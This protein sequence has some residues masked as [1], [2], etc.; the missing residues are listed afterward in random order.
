M[1]NKVKH[2]ER[3]DALIYCRVSTNKQEEKDTIKSQVIECEKYAK[4][5]GYRIAEVV[6]E[7]F[8]GRIFI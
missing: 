1:N 2:N 7:T 8:F 3:K 6:E 4:A 5:N